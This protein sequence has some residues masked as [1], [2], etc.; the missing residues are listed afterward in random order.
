MLIGLVWGILAVRLDLGEFTSDWIR[1]WGTIFI[2]L[3]KLIAV[4]LVFVSIVQGVSSLSDINKLGSLGLKTLGLY[5]LS[6]LGTVIIGLAMVN[7]IKPGNTF[8]EEKRA[9]YMER[10][11]ESMQE[12]SSAAEDIKE[13]S[14]LQFLVDVVP[15]NIFK[16]SADNGNMLQIIFFALLMGAAVIMISDRKSGP[17]KT[18][19]ESIHEILLKLIDIIMK[20][21]PLGVL[22]L[23][24]SLVVDFSGDSDL[25]KALLLYFMTVVIGLL[26]SIFLFYPVFLKV[27]APKVRFIKFLRGI[28]PAQIIAFTTSSSAATLPVTMKQNIEE[29]GVS[30]DITNFVLPVGTTVN[31]DGTACY[32]AI[33]AVFIAQVFG[34]DLT[35]LQQIPI[36]LTAILAAIGAP[37]IPGGSIVMLVLVL[38]SAG[39]PIEGLAL[40]IGIDRPLD[41]LRTVV[42][43]TGD[44]A[45]NVVVGKSENKIDRAKLY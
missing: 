1:P 25:F 11:Q 15:D 22:A 7:T 30:E 40:I 23:L 41:M 29:L 38:S 33:A 42:N 35:L 37:G 9:V 39:I 2:R 31:M 5:F 34:M 20:F 44:T 16:S 13:Q 43:V 26:L 24:A 6:M 36:I 19:I 3:L 21:A 18:L 45:V 12:K 10:Y 17:F 4:P 27:F 32:Q 28:F 14:P 8:P